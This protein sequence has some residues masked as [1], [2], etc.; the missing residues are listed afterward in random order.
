VLLPL[1]KIK[2]TKRATA[3][4]IFSYINKPPQNKSLGLYAIRI[5][6]DGKTNN[7]SIYQY[8]EGYIYANLIEHPIGY[9]L[10]TDVVP[11]LEVEVKMGNGDPRK[12][13]RLPMPMLRK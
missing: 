11:R 12:D 4:L 9:K 3:S 10:E 6:I 7:E 8:F 1:Q 13:K 5:R 2:K